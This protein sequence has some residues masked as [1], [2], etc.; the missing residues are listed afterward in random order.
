[1]ISYG[2]GGVSGA[3]VEQLSD[4]MGVG[5]G[6]FILGAGNGADGTGKCRNKFLD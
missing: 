1:M 5:F 4:G 6:S 2:G 3:I